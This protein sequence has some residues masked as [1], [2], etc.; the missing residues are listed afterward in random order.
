MLVSRRSRIVD[1]SLVPEMV[2]PAKPKKHR[3]AEFEGP[4]IACRCGWHY[5][6]H[7]F[8]DYGAQ[9]L[10]DHLLDHYN[11]HRAAGAQRGDEADDA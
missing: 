1:L 8:Q 5:R 7:K 10:A 4:F 3:V 11:A 6:E 9:S 2:M